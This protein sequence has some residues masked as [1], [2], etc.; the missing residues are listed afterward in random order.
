MKGY[1]WMLVLGAGVVLGIVASTV[2]AFRSSLVSTG[3]ASD[4][5]GEWVKYAGASGDTVMA[6]IAFPERSDAAP[7]VIV[8]H[9][10]FGLSDWVRSVA[11]RLAEEGFVAIAPDLLSRR[12]GTENAA[13]PRRVIRDLP[14]D[15]IRVD[16]DATHD[17]LRA[18]RSVRTDAVGVVG[19]C[20]G[21]GR[22]FRYATDNPDLRAVVVCY[23]SAPEAA[24]MARIKAP[25][26]GIYAERDA[27]INA[28]LA[29][30]ERA[31][32]AAGK[33]YVKTVYP[34]AGH[35]FLRTIRPRA[36]AEEAW[37]DVLRFLDEELNR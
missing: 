12:G 14:P 20:W 33:R 35:G 15:S 13:Q 36:V 8:I 2:T 19:F 6:Y 11:D 4:V 29:G 28:N 10:I 3:R 21:G 37:R 22:S 17:Y 1:R 18:L 23:G 5:H 34:E 27:R 31:M 16:L 25:V 7:A 26:L 24:E 32:R 30:V 9:E